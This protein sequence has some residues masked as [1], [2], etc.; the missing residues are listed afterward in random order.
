MATFVFVVLALGSIAHGTA[1]DFVPHL[2]ITISLGLVLVDLAVL[3]YFIHH[4]ATS[5]QLPR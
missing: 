5:I 3:V 2:S 4:V 1:G